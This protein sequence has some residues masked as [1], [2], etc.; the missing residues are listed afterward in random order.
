MR[1]LI[2]TQKVDENDDI[3]GFFV[4]W[5]RAL[6][7][8]V[9]RIDVICLAKGKYDLPPHVHVHSLGKEKRFPKWLQAVV[10]YIDALLFLPPAD[11]VFVH[12][13]P[14]YVRA[15][16]PL[17]VFCKKPIIMWYAHIK[18]SP[19]AK[20]AMDHV[21]RILTP[22]KESFDY[23]SMK[24]VSTGHGIDV[25]V[26]APKTAE[27]QADVL[28]LSRISKVKRI[29][30]LIEAIRI[31]SEKYPKISVDIYGE[32]ARPEDREYLESLKKLVKD[33]GLER[34]ISWKGGVA[35]RN[36]PQVYAE[37]KIF[38]RLQGGGGFGKTELEAMSMGIPAIVPTSVY[39]ADLLELGRDLYFPEDD[40]V[41]LAERIVTVLGW[42][43]EKRE[44]YAK[45]ARSIVVEKHNVEHVAEKII[46]LLR[47]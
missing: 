1:L 10:F 11:G 12:M 5:L 8:R 25:N 2:I 28:T 17:N 3:L 13:A 23:E 31:V 19:L 15:L 35:N 46:E 32:P 30:T 9:D 4:F 27:V 34:N 18:V 40:A 41:A 24:V 33:S 22:S 7:K 26:F 47:K 45:I 6:A 38:V 37:H 44:A 14:E 20:W 36:S 43:D 29:E 42:P 21:Y 39:K 16:H